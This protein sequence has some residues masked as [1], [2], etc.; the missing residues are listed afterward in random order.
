MDDKRFL[1]TCTLVKGGSDF[2][3]FETE[4]ELIWTVEND[5]AIIP[6][7]AIEIGNVRHIDLEEI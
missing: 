6:V 4:E 7:E 3:W 2:M 1:L 5:K